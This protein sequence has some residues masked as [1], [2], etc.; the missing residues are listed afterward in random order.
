MF[1]SD[2]LIWIF[3]SSIADASHIKSLLK[4]NKRK[5]ELFFSLKELQ[6]KITKMKSYDAVPNA[7]IGDIET[8]EGDFFGLV[9]TL[10]AKKAEWQEKILV[11]SHV[12]YGRF[13]EECQS[14]QLL[15]PYLSKSRIEKDLVKKVDELLK[16]AESGEAVEQPV[17]SPM[18]K[19]LA[20]RVED[21]HKKL[22]DLYYDG[23]ATG[24]DKKGEQFKALIADMQPLLVSVEW[25][26]LASHAQMI[27]TKKLDGIK[28]KREVKEFISDCDSQLEK[29]K[30]D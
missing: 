9:D 19:R 6:D 30:E 17:L 15:L 10:I 24:G 5:F 27:S 20:R 1:K 16:T 18:K 26:S 14:R 23:A 25:K 22:K 7:V 3:D 12:S 28:L 8:P 21:L 4:K 13:L 2:Q 11:C 29:I